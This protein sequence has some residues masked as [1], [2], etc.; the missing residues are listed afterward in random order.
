[1]CRWIHIC[2][3]VMIWLLEHLGFVS[4]NIIYMLQKPDNANWTTLIEILVLFFV[5]TLIRFI[6]IFCHAHTKGLF[7]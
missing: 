5:T 7:V 1:M 4:I 2:A 3:S 6:I